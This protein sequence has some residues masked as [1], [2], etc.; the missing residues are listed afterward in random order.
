M[1]FLNKQAVTTPIVDTVFAVSR[2]A[3]EAI[4]VHGRDAVTNATLGTLLDEDNQLV[5]FDSVFNNYNNMDN[6][7]KASYASSIAG[8]DSFREH[9]WHWVTRGI[10]INLHHSVIATSGGTGALSTTMSHI[11]DRGETIILPEIGWGPYTMMADDN[12]LSYETYTMFDGD[13]FNLASFKETCLR[14]LEK[15]NKL[16]IVMNDPCHN[17]TGYSMTK[18]EWQEVISFINTCSEKAPCVI[19]NDVAYIDYGYHANETNK[20][21]EAFHELSENAIVMIAFSLSKSLTSYG[22]RCGAAIIV[23]QNEKA[24][25]EIETVFEKSARARWSNIAN[26]A[27]ENFVEVTTTRRAQFL[28]EKAKYV[29]LLKKRSEV[30]LSEAITCKLP[31]Y[32][33]KEG[34][35][36]TIAVEDPKKLDAF[37]QA[38]IDNLIFTIK[39]K[40]GIRVA[41]CSLTIDNCYGLATKMK[42]ILDTV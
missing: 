22:L 13:H 19:L 38:L 21:M 42:K 25:K 8:N 17:P 15:Q 26:G 37:H 40:K 10:D 7:K 16:L 24:V 5:A 23:G 32:P 27:M 36:I 1:Q 35:F 9:V 34:F 3:K 12:G 28:Q 41:L 30:F 20:Y 6:R 4:Q 14:V 11:L 2:L 31:C 18:A 39:V 29:D 33:Y